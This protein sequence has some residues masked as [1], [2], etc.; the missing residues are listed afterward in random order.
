MSYMRIFVLV[1]VA[2]AVSAWPEGAPLE[3][4]VDLEAIHEN[5]AQTDPPPYAIEALNNQDGTYQANIIITDNTPPFEFFEGW[6][7]QARLQGSTDPLG[8]WTNLANTSHT[9]DCS[10]PGDT[11]TQYYQHVESQSMTWIPPAGPVNGIHFHATVI[12]NY[13]LHWTNLVSGDLA[14]APLKSTQG[15][16]IVP[17]F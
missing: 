2:V 5:P 11:V 13:S 17:S 15:M 16:F 4:C 10:A 6:M 9:I 3:S 7:V 12:R 14:A 1:A 8:T